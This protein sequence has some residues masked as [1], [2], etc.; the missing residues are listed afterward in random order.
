MQDSIKNPNP[1][2][3]RKLILIVS[4][5]WNY[6]CMNFVILAANIGPLYRTACT[7]YDPLYDALVTT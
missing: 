3:I 5:A 7:E 1:A 2:E 4:K 6:I